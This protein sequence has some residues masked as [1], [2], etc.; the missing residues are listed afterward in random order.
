[1][2]EESIQFFAFFFGLAGAALII[3][4]GV[5][6][7]ARILQTEVLKKDQPYNVIRR[8]FT[9]K[10]IFALE[11]FIAADVLRTLISPTREEI[12]LLGAIVGIRTILAYFL[13][14]EA[15]DLQIA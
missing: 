13:S 3:Y 9:F 2:F 15:K 12:I 1:M 8:D 4:G 11:F 14:K 6:A 5:I 10:I 7:I